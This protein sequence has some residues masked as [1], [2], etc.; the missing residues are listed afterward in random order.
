MESRAKVF[1]HALHQMLVVFP[2]GLLV[3]SLIFDVIGMVTGNGIWHQ[4][5]F[6]MIGAGV[7]TGLLAAVPGLIDWFAIPMGT[8]AKA[9]GMWHGVGNIAVIALFAIAWLIRRGQPSLLEPGAIAFVLSFIAVGMGGVTAWLGGEL[10]DRLGVGIDKGAN[11]N[12]PSSLSGR[13]ASDTPDPV[14]APSPSE[15]RP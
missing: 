2:L 7:I 9:I 11:L 4:S 13:P 3:M 1:G 14:T 5:A 12:A 6:Y 10:V 15:A 8:R